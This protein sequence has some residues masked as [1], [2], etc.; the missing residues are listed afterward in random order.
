[1]NNSLYSEAY[2][3]CLH[4]MK[5]FSDPSDISASLQPPCPGRYP[6]VSSYRRQSSI[7]TTL[8][9]QPWETASPC[10]QRVTS[11]LSLSYL[12]SFSIRYCSKQPT[13]GP[14]DTSTW[15]TGPPTSARESSSSINVDV[16]MRR[17]CMEP[18]RFDYVMRCPSLTFVNRE[19]RNIM[20]DTLMNYRTGSRLGTQKQVLRV[21]FAHLFFRC[22]GGHRDFPLSAATYGFQIP[23]FRFPG[24]PKPV[25]AEKER[26]RE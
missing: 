21:W 20:Y 4:T 5:V 6:S 23:D 11:I 19:S 15:W 13:T 3:L 18:E 8:A 14:I 2:L 16:D 7:L 12:S 22:C 17:I 25:K 10:H 24:L 9:N 26:L 1:M